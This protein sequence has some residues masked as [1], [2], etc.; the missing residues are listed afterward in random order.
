M[1]HELNRCDVDYILNDVLPNLNKVVSGELSEYEFG[2][3]VTII[4]FNKDVS[5]INYNFFENT[6]EVPSEDIYKFMQEWGERLREWKASNNK[7]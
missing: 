7:L 1:L 4:D 5:V 3:D 2:F 6:M